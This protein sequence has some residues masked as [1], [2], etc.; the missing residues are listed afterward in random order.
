[1]IISI[2]IKK[3]HLDLGWFSDE[4]FHLF[5]LIVLEV[6]S[7]GATLL[8]LQCAKLVFEITII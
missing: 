3:F 2:N 5:S 1:M 8:H 4:D 7:A 6:W